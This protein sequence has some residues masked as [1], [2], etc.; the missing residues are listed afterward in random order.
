M[1]D[2][3]TCHTLTSLLISEKITASPVSAAAS[4]IK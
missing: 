4:T 3:P 2:R 1:D